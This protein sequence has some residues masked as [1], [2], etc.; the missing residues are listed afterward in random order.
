MWYIH[1]ILDNKKK[2]MADTKTWRNG[3]IS[4]SAHRKKPDTK[5]KYGIIPPISELKEL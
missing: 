4:K 3:C 5:Y 1:G 2:Q